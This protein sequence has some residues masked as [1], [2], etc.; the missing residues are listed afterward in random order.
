MGKVA[1]WRLILPRGGAGFQKS[2]HS[3]LEEQTWPWGGG[4]VKR[5]RGQREEGEGGDIPV[6]HS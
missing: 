2:E 3:L 1:R 6:V 4:G 5:G